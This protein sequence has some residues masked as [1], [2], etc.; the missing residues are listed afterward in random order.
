MA[1]NDKDFFGNRLN[2]AQHVSHQGVA[3]YRM[4]HLG[5]PGL[6]ASTFTRSED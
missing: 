3:A 1:D 5:L 4:K 2:G 6:H